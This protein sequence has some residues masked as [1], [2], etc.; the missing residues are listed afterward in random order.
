[1]SVVDEARRTR[2]VMSDVAITV[3]LGVVFGYALVES[4][5]FPFRA[6]LVPKV[7]SSAGLGFVVLHLIGVVVRAMRPESETSD[8]EPS[9]QPQDATP[10][11]DYDFA[12]ANGCEWAGTL[13]WF[14]L[15]FALLWLV[16]T[17]IAVPVFAFIY[18]VVVTRTALHWALA[19]SAVVWLLFYLVFGRVLELGLPGGMLVLS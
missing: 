7:I 8:A 15:F 17:L 4:L 14:A 11:T 1:M 13:G 18:L 2:G 16:G 5:S 12:A 6:G 3:V 10:S 19:Y 9:E